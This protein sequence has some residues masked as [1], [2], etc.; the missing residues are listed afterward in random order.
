[1]K[2]SFS[3]ILWWENRPVTIAILSVPFFISNLAHDLHQCFVSSSLSSILGSISLNILTMNYYPVYTQSSPIVLLFLSAICILQ[4]AQWRG[5][6]IWESKYS[7]SLCK[8]KT[9]TE[10][11]R[12]IF[13]FS[14][15]YKLLPHHLLVVNQSIPHMTPPTKSCSTRLMNYNQKFLQ[16]SK[17][18]KLLYWQSTY[19]ECYRVLNI[20]GGKNVKGKNVTTGEEPLEHWI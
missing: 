5:S 16:N 18:P 14:S 19:F 10:V 4:L 8:M 7:S 15:V 11:L 17:L 3:K 1:M 9:V 2:R 13:H 6:E 20:S 12:D